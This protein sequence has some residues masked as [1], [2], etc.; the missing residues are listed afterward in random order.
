[1]SA[2][3]LCLSA[4]VAV[5]L[6]GL[7][8]L[9]DEAKQTF[10]DLHNKF[11]KETG[12]DMEDLVWD[13]TLAKTAQEY[14]K[15]CEF[16]HPAGNKYGENIYLGWGPAFT[17]GAAEAAKATNKWHTE[18]ANVDADWD[19]IANRP[20]ATCGHFS[21]QIWANTKKLGCAITTECKIFG[22]VWNLVFCEYDPA[23]NMMKAYDYEN[24]KYIPNAPY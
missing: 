24:Q 5:T 4:L 10:I 6:A 8:D 15:K 23:G 22:K 1:M 16:H 17:T 9:D 2:I 13:D 11:R 18:I 3:L 7:V 14:S 12:A 20:K 21:Q 19:C